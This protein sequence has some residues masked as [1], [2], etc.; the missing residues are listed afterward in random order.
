MVLKGWVTSSIITTLHIYVYYFNTYS[1][2]LSIIPF[3][4]SLHNSFQFYRYIGVQPKKALIVMT[5]V[6][7][8]NTA[9]V[10]LVTTLK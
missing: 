8:M 1:I 6:T 9:C 2:S 7:C 10:G 5:P 3:I 4:N